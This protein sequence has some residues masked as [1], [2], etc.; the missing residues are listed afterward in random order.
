[1]GAGGAGETG[2]GF[3]MRGVLLILS[4]YVFTKQDYMP[5]QQ[6]MMQISLT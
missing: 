6:V 3:V 2:G 5:S 1:M 4:E